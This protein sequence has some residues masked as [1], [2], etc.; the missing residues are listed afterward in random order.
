MTVPYQSAGICGNSTSISSA[1]AL[2]PF[3]SSVTSSGGSPSTSNRRQM[4]STS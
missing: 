4:Q 3:D 1:S 2:K